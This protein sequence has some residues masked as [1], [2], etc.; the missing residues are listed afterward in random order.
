MGRPRQGAVTSSI[1]SGLPAPPITPA[2]NAAQNGCRNTFA[3][4]MATPRRRIAP[5]AA[6]TKISAAADRCS[7]PKITASATAPAA[8]ASVNNH[9]E[10]GGAR[11]IAAIAA[12]ALSGA[13]RRV[14]I[15]PIACMV[16]ATRSMFTPA[17]SAAMAQFSRPLPSSAR[18]CSSPQRGMMLARRPR[19]FA[20]TLAR[21]QGLVGG[22]AIDVQI[23]GWPR[24]RDWHAPPTS[25]QPPSH[26][27]TTKRRSPHRASPSFSDRRRDRIRPR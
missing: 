19:Q 9:V 13:S 21:G 17:G 3:L 12:S 16:E 10:A 4:Y 25:C 14:P 23:P 11:E 20:E 6:L 27:A 2:S 26:A 7:T 1:R 18:S 22:L 8:A 15:S 24:G 5:A